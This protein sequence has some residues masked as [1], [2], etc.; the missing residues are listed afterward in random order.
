[1]PRALAK[2]G[3]LLTEGVRRISIYQN[4]TIQAVQDDLGYALGRDSGGSAI[5][6]WR[7]GYIPHN[8]AEVERLA[9]EIVRQGNLGREWLEQFLVSADHPDPAQLCNEMFPPYPSPLADI[10]RASQKLDQGNTSVR[11]SAPLYPSLVVGR[12]RAIADLRARLNVSLAS[13]QSAAS[14][15][16]LTAVHGWPGVGKTTLAA[17][18]AHDPEIKLAFPDG[19]LW[20]SLGQSPDLLA[21]LGGWMRVLGMGDFSPDCTLEEITAQLTAALRD[22]RRFLIVD[23]VWEV[24]HAIPFKVGGGGCAMLVTTRLP[25]V[26][27]ALAPTSH[28]VYHLS[29]LAE[30]D[31]LELLRRL[32]PNVVAEHLEDCQKLVCEL[33]GLPLALQVAGRLLDVEASYGWAVQ[34][35]LTEI[36]DGARLLEAEPPPDLAD[37]VGQTPLT[38]AVLLKKSTNHLDAVTRDCFAYL[39]VFAPKPATFDLEVMKAIWAVPDPKPIA[40]RLIARGLLEPVE[41]GRFTIHALLVMLAKSLLTESSDAQSL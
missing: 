4:R 10:G 24:Q 3:S 6:Y 7:K 25:A 34:D 2:F 40:R 13:G 8:P 21:E 39:G 27:Q 9:W 19:I 28:N 29:V 23:D 16:V 22:R 15:Q 36:Q 14:M 41:G 20:A 32:A 38:V 33:E 17:A 5:E 26:A 31:G 30:Q 11:G 35:L 18:L 1:M 37:W 12:E